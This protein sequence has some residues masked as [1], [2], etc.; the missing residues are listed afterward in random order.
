M[1]PRPTTL[2]LGSESKLRFQSTDATT[3][4]SSLLVNNINHDSVT[5]ELEGD[6]ISAGHQN[7]KIESWENCLDMIETELNNTVNQ[8]LAHDT[9]TD[10]RMNRALSPPGSVSHEKQLAKNRYGRKKSAS[11]V[12]ETKYHSPKEGTIQVIEESGAVQ[13]SIISKTPSTYVRVIRPHKGTVTL[14]KNRYHKSHPAYEY[15]VKMTIKDGYQEVEVQNLS[16]SNSPG[17]IVNTSPLPEDLM[18]DRE[19]NK[20]DAL[21]FQEMI[22]YSLDSGISPFFKVKNPHIEKAQEIV[23]QDGFHRE[24]DFTK[25]LSPEDL[26]EIAQE[27]SIKDLQSSQ[28][29]HRENSDQ[30]ERI[31]YLQ[32]ISE[33]SSMQH[34][35]R[36]DPA[37]I[38]KPNMEDEENKPMI[39]DFDDESKKEKCLI[40]VN[41]MPALDIERKVLRKYGSELSV[42]GPLCSFVSPRK[43]DTL[44]SQ[45]RYFRQ[46]TGM[47]KDEDTLNK[48]FATDLK[49]CNKDKIIKTQTVSDIVQFDWSG[50]DLNVYT[51][52][53]KLKGK[54]EGEKISDNIREK[55]ENLIKIRKSPSYPDSELVLWMNG[56]SSLAIVN[57]ST[58]THNSVPGFW[59]K[60]NINGLGLFTIAG[61]DFFKLAGMGFFNK[62]YSLHVACYNMESLEWNYIERNISALMV[63]GKITSL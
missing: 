44:N 24:E 37:V 6:F 3:K 47:S 45:G 51:A 7:Q 59:G 22:K 35:G 55:Y 25:A 34:S 4:K 43:T 42:D 12:C 54:L 13:S 39:V 50:F 36:H 27:E 48:L 9:S 32:T 16:F 23:A 56:P 19:M 28:I 8:I 63:K 41:V 62:R 38:Q 53:G 57:T 2:E 30:S 46:F 20:N 21:I 26:E 5:R 18:I 60:D 29:R 17:V 15:P 11:P 33:E 58:L 40:E 61:H 10:F 31:N 14:H 1:T 52:K 49:S